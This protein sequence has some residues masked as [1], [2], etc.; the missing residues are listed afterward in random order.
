M[1]HFQ[2]SHK[3]ACAPGCLAAAQRPELSPFLGLIDGCPE[4]RMQ[5]VA[6]LG[7]LSTLCSAWLY[8]RTR[9]HYYRVTFVEVHQHDHEVE[10][11]HLLLAGQEGGEERKEEG[12]SRHGA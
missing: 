7:V 4:L 12:S 6:G 3:S 9:E 10:G 11:H 5:I 1:E 8:S 2:G